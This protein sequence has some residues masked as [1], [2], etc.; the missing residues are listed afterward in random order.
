MA[1]RALFAMKETEIEDRAAFAHR[2][3]SHAVL[4]IHGLCGTPHEMAPLAAR[5]RA[6][7]YVVSVPLGPGYDIGAAVSGVVDRYERWV[8]YFAAQFDELASRHARVSIGGLCVGANIA[9]E[10]A[11][12]RGAVSSLVLISTTLFYDGW[13]VSRLRLLLPLGYYT[14]LRRWYRV[15]ETDPYGLKNMRLRGWVARQMSRAGGSIGGAASLPLTAIYQ[16]ER[17]IRVVKRSLRAV[18]VPTLVMHAREDDVS[19]L[20]SADLVCSRIRSRE[21]GYINAHG[22][23]TQAGDAAETEAI[24]AAFGEHARALAVSSTKSMHGHLMGAAGA[25]EPIVAILAL[26]HRAL[27]PTAHLDVRDPHCDLDYIANVA[28]HE[29]D[30]SV[31]MSSSFAFGGANAVL[32]ARR[33]GGRQGRKRRRAS[34]PTST[35]RHASSV[36]ASSS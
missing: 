30:V 34:R 28:R 13:N 23:G 33:Y 27:P 36:C 11:A 20:R 1:F 18:S 35:H 8:E 16:A 6:S 14:P 32:L 25:L 15:R 4:L 2:A 31:A 9:I 21:V 22:T 26:R 29:A 7:G 5:L 24:K 12:Q 17:L 19:S 10:I 3:G